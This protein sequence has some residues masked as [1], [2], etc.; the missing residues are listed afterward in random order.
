[1]PGNTLPLA[2]PD[3][4]VSWIDL[5]ARPGAGRAGT[6]LGRRLGK[7]GCYL[8]TDPPKLHRFEL[9]NE[10]F[11]EPARPAAREVLRSRATARC[12]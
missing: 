5:V 3:A 8:K 6:H 12:W 7:A 1:M 11:G 2:D 10:G 4:R 9:L